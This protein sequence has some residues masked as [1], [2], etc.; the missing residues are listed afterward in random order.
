MIESLKTNAGK[1]YDDLFGNRD[2]KFTVKDLPNHA[3]LIVVLVVDLL[4]LVAEFRVGQVGYK[5][6]GSY[7]LAFG[8]VTVSSLPFY[9]GQIAYIYNR[10]NK[11]QLAIAVL[12]V[13]MG[14]FASGYYGFADYVVSANSAIDLNG[15]LIPLDEN[16]LF[17]VAV[18]F[19]VALVV[20][21]LLYVLV[22]DEIANN[23]KIGRLRAKA[24]AA[25]KELKLRRDV[26]ASLR[27]TRL[28]EESLKIQFPDDYEAFSNAMAGKKN[29]TSGSGK[30][31]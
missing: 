24:E 26:L 22:D 11:R 9:M 12:M 7:L 31:S 20:G 21:G 17:A 29:P 25:Q 5:L 10:A 19:A 8:F 23:L 30:K 28:Q 3:I 4:M 6:T 2:G 15:T 1:Y 14:L 18:C 16:T 27:E 13:C